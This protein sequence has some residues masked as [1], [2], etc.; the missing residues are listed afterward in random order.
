MFLILD[1]F[2]FEVNL[3]QTSTGVLPLLEF[4]TIRK[5]INLEAPFQTG[6]AHLL[7]TALDESIIMQEI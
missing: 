6:V 2:V 1:I 7:E 4:Q 5:G 3:I